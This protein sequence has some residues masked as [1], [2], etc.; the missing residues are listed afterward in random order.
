MKVRSS[1]DL[2]SQSEEPSGGIAERRVRKPL[3]MDYVF[4]P[5]GWT[6]HDVEVGDL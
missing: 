3:H 4:V 1:T 2:L 6:I 5:A